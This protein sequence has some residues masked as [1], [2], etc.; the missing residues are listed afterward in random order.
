MINGP[1]EDGTDRRLFLDELVAR[2]FLSDWKLSFWRPGLR[3]DV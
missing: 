3:R 2:L 1:I